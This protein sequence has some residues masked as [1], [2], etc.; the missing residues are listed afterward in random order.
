[1]PEPEPEAARRRPPF[2]R[3]AALFLIGCAVLVVPLWVVRYPPLLDY[4][5]HLASSYV[6][7]HIHDQRY[8]FSRWYQ[9]DWTPSPYVA[10]DAALVVLQRFLPVEVAGRVMLSLCVVGLPL[11]VWFF[12]RQ[13]Q[14]QHDL[15][16]MWAFVLAYN[17]FFLVGFLQ[18]CL[19]IAGCFAVLG[20]WI[21]YLG[22]PTIAR[23]VG[24]FAAAVTLYFTHLFGFAV[25]GLVV[26]LYA[27]VRR[28]SLRQLGL[29]WLAFLP[30]IALLLQPGTSAQGAH[31][32]VLGTLAR[33]VKW[34]FALVAV[35]PRP[36]EPMNLVVFALLALA[37]LILATAVTGLRWKR[38]WI[39]VAAA[40]LVIYG[41]LPAGYEFRG[42]DVLLD[43]R[44]LPFL[45]IIA[46]AAL[47]IDRRRALIAAAAVVL[48]LTVRM[49]TLTQ[50]FLADQASLA[51]LG[52][53]FSAI[54]ANARVLPMWALEAGNFNV[55]LFQP[56]HFWSYGVISRGWLS[57][58]LFSTG[59]HALRWTRGEPYPSWG[60][61]APAYEAGLEWE[62]VR[63]TYDYVWAYH[64]PELSPELRK[65]GTLVFADE[66][67]EVF[68]LR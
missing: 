58:Y 19:S 54:P 53:S 39:T 43:A 30:G 27:L 31:T 36:S 56:N 64:L 25:A 29:S 4:P 32:F 49:A 66:G 18:Y 35:H 63:R 46:F 68:K 14:A 38:G 28:L 12:A 37:V 61:W 42:N 20:V 59:A 41:L 62:R 23:W 17:I 21:W 8:Q 60:L 1:M 34:L 67:L 3:D 9:A 7:A 6:L 11:S 2:G 57:P 33:K 44:L 22:R 45:V 55:L 13:M 51:R 5:N 47:E 65:I 40:L 48:L 52:R 15:A 24:L 50:Y 26:T 16:V 10:T